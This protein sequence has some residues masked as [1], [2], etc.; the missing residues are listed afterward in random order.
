MEVNH[1]ELA[2][3]M[4]RCYETNT[5]IDVKGA[6][7]VGKS[8]VVRDVAINKASEKK[9]KFI[10]WNEISIEEKREF[11]TNKEKVKESFFFV[12]IRLSQIDSS[13]LKGLPNFNKY[14]VVEWQPNLIWKILSYPE[15][16]GIVFFDELNLSCPS[17]MAS[18]YQII[19]DHQ[20]GEYPHP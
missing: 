1:K 20:I 4:D 19:N 10:E 17:V 14:D 7:G 16:D 3:C 2:L 13:D 11:I 5:S 12:D 9:K 15:A 18:C 6:T 8:F